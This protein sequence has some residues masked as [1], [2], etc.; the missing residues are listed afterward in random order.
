MAFVSIGLQTNSVIHF[1]DASIA[2]H[3]AASD[4]NNTKAM[5][6]DC[7]KKRFPRSQKQFKTFVREATA[8]V[9]KN[10]GLLKDKGG[11]CGFIKKRIGKKRRLSVEVNK[12]LLGFNLVE[13]QKGI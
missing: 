6:F 12:N 11:A 4:C 8:G 5:V 1:T 3:L 13:V 9:A 2:E 10:A 7:L